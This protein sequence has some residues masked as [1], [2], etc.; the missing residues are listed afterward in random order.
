MDVVG[1]AVEIINPEQVSIITLD[2]PL[3]TLAKHIQWSWPDTYSEN[4]FVVIFGGLQIEMTIIKILSDLPQGSGWTASLVQADI[5][6]TGATDS[7]LSASHVTRTRNAHQVTA[8]AL[9]GLLN[10]SMWHIQVNW[11]KMKI[12]SPLLTVVLVDPFSL[13]VNNTTTRNY[14]RC[15]PVHI[16]GMV[17]SHAKHPDVHMNVFQRGNF[18]YWKLVEHFWQYL[19]TKAANRTM[20]RYRM[21]VVLWASQKILP[22]YKGEWFHAQRWPG[23]LRNL[24]HLVIPEK[25][26]TYDTMSKTN[27]HWNDLWGI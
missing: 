24:Q 18:Q 9:Y 1:K 2:Q 13:L 14:A 11:L 10:N 6:S 23:L 25:T 20:L 4:H 12:Y 17:S 3:Y 22:H 19:L 27:T 21:M 7:L 8:Y 5:V 15:I 26:L 16:R